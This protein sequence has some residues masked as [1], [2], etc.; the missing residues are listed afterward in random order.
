VSQIELR[1]DDRWQ[2]S[3]RWPA[4]LDAIAGIVVRLG[5]KQVAGDL[6]VG[7]SV[8]SNA[9]RE[10]DRH[11][12]RMEWLPHLLAHDHDGALSRA[13]MA[14]TDRWDVTPRV[15]LTP[16]QENARLRGAIDALPEAVRDAL[17]SGAGVRR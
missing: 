5:L 2:R 13:L 3:E 9:L 6:D 1:Y 15:E 7:P 10:R 11:A 14:C 8:L 17:Y 16:A 12:L 4:V